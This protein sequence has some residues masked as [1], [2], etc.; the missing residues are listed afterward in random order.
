[1]NHSKAATIFNTNEKK[2]DWHDKA[3]WF[4]RHKRD[5]SVHAVEGWETLRSLGHGIKAHTLSNL[6]NYL[7]QFEEN[8]LKNGVQVHWAIDGDEH[9]RIVLSILKEHNAKKVVKSKCFFI[10]I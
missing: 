7:I 1:M 5:K 2:V 3:L 4:V 6:D 10:A 9:N 8:A